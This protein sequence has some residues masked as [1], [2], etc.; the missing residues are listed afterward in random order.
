MTAVPASPE[1]AR[2]RGLDLRL[3]LPALVAWAV[4]ATL[5]PRD[6]VELA[7]V[8]TA[9]GLLGLVVLLRVRH[10]PVPGR[11]RYD[12]PDRRDRPVVT[13]HRPV[14]ALCLL[15]TALV[16]GCGAADHAVS[17]AGT[18]TELAAERAVVT[19]EATALTEPR[20]VSRGDE[21]PD[22]VVLQ[23]RLQRVEG[24]GTSQQV[25]A[26]VVVF[27]DEA[28]RQ[29]PWRAR[30]RFVGRLSPPDPGTE[31]V[32]A[33]AP[34]G[35]VELVAE[36]GPVLRAA[37]VARERLRAAMAPLPPDARGL[38]PGL[39]IGD[40]SLTPP[41]LS[42]AMLTTGMSHLSAVSGSNVAIVL[43]A[44]VLLCGAL[45]V[46]VRWRPPLAVLALAGFV[47]LC[48]PEP[49]VLRAGAMGLVGLL[50]LTTSRR[51]ASLPALGVAVVVLL[52]WDPWLARSYGFALS[53]LATLGLVVFA[54]PWGDAMGRRLPRP[55]RRLGDPWTR[56]W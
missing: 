44:V 47:L 25:A 13:D 11:G 35:G 1:E 19:A 5:V 10:R 28:W 32:A 33:V 42:E 37:D 48:R 38:I 15:T 46:G 22:L 14:A 29:V 41:E 52:C 24:R 34:V 54:R 53:T 16:L 26:P 7:V 45:G 39:V 56:S 31:V 30:V 6:P 51:R 18:V 17:R 8:A 9:A 43:G 3:L 55:V 40:T 20:L 12:G 23:A 50:A 27:A 36:P 2:P 21:R 4:L 49:S